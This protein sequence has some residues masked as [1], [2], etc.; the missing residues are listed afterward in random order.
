MDGK[1]LILVA[2]SLG[3]DS[4]KPALLP[5]QGTPDGDV[6]VR[7]RRMLVL[8]DC[9]PLEV[10]IGRLDGGR[11]RVEVVLTDPRDGATVRRSGELLVK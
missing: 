3:F 4:G 1:L 10:G 9:V 5:G 7:F 8:P 11:Y 2:G 6:T